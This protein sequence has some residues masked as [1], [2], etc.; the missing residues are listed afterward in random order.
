MIR[1][2]LLPARKVKRAADP[3]SKALL[4]GLSGLVAVALIIILG[5][6]GPRRAQ[7]R[8]L[9]ESNKKL[10]TALAD[11]SKALVGY[12]ETSALVDMRDARLASIKRLMT[13][14]VVPANVLHELGEILTPGHPPTMTEVMTGLT[15]KGGDPNKEYQDDWDASHV[16]LSAFVDE[17]GTF[18]LEGGAQT[19]ADVTQL[20]K[21]LAASAYFMDVNP[22]GGE[23]VADAQSGLTYYKFTITGKIAY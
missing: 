6:D 3:S 5:I 22:A 23:K 1:I 9:D 10:A 4:F 19:E 2:N 20:S 13:A 17:G 14:Q 21:R 12:K 7:L 15:S 11:Q 16:W 8:Q 18:K